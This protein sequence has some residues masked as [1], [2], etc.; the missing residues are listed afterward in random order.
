M[1]VYR[2]ICALVACVALTACASGGLD[3]SKLPPIVIP[4]PA[5]EK[6]APAK[7]RATLAFE[8][9]DACTG[10]PL[11]DVFARFSDNSQ[12]QTDEHGYAAFEKD[13][14]VDDKPAVYAVRFLLDD[15]Y[16]SP[17][18]EFA[19]VENRQF[20]VRL[21]PIAGCAKPEPP[22][23]PA[24]EPVKPTPAPEPP[25][26]VT[27]PPTP[28]PC[29]E[30]ECVRQTAE[31]YP[32]LLTI[33]TYESCLEFTQR[34]LERLPEYGHVGKT[35]GESQSVPQGFEPRDVRGSDGNLYRITGV[36]HDAIKHKVTGQVID[37]LG[38]A[39]A[40]SDPDPKIHGPARIQW[41]VVPV[42]FN[43]VQNPY[44]PA[45]PVR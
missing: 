44:I 21:R 23:A 39:S 27:P 10:A 6:P 42:E 36:S 5:V 15:T 26:V 7:P 24:P 12:K 31:K 13:A 16:E 29:V 11:R 30:I 43:R 19:L 28:A 1:K 35:A 25:P 33:N 45:V 8:V 4:P 32:H 41:A 40:N 38:N 37:L 34:V 18:R 22:P 9:L 17:T 3:L 2:L 14:G 20:Q